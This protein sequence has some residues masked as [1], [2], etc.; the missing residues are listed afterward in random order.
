M[1]L[2]YLNEDNAFNREWKT[3]VRVFNPGLWKIRIAQLLVHEAC[4][5]KQFNGKDWSRFNNESSQKLE[6]DC[7]Y[8]WLYILELLGGNEDI[9]S[10]MKKS[11]NKPNW[12]WWNW[13]KKTWKLWN[14]TEWLM[15]IL[16]KEKQKEYKVF[17]DNYIYE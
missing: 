1:N 13:W 11:A 6:N 16:P 9:I 17:W 15:D 2:H 5:W 8:L 7:T 12:Y 14:T 10:H 4:H 3:I